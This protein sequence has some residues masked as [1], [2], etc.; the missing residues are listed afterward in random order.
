MMVFVKK[1]SSLEWKTVEVATGLM[2]LSLRLLEAVAWYGSRSLLLWR[3]G[4]SKASEGLGAAGL[5]EGWG[6][7]GW[8]SGSTVA[9]FRGT[10]R[11]RKKVEIVELLLDTEAGLDLDYRWIFKTGA[12]PILNVKGKV[13]QYMNHPRSALR[14]AATAILVGVGEPVVGSLIS[15]LR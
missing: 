3:G 13:R 8:R 5:G 4:L 6:K 14:S 15:D 7:S 11:R 2:K 1:G 10:V 9:D 12:W